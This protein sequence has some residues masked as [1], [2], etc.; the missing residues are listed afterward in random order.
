[1]KRIKDAGMLIQVLGWAKIILPFI[2][3]ILVSSDDFLKSY[4]EYSYT[5]LSFIICVGIIFVILG[6]RIHKGPDK[7]TKKY[8]WFIAVVSFLSVLI[9]A[10]MG[11]NTLSIVVLVAS[12]YGIWS[13]KKVSI[14][15]EI[16]KYK[17]SGY[18]YIGIGLLMLL[19]IFSGLVMG[20]IYTLDDGNVHEVSNE[21][22]HLYS[23]AEYN[24][25][26]LLPEGWKIAPP[27]RPS[28][29]IVQR[30]VNGSNNIS[31]MVNDLGT[32]KNSVKEFGTAEEMAKETVN[33]A[34]SGNVSNIKL[35]DFG[36][37]TISENP[38]YWVSFSAFYKEADTEFTSIVYSIIKDGKL[39]NI[40]SLSSSEDFSEYLPIFQ[41][42]SE[43][44]TFKK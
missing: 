6:S 27:T 38:T 18:K 4:L 43:S 31:V 23:N 22:S 14:P 32:T 28:E 26:I 24:F 8:L 5:D 39:Y 16:P 21:V 42:A 20:I 3:P 1:M 44:F 17:I 41:E 15:E 30:A 33:N 40:S 11:T 25:S 19:T 13:L 9:N 34:K 35:L 2:V 10:A 29:T 7:N 37:V 12:V 36:E